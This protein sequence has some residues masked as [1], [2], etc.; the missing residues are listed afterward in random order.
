MLLERKVGKEVNDKSVVKTKV[1]VGVRG[2]KD[3]QSSKRTG[4]HRDGVQHWYKCIDT[5]NL[6]LTWH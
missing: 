1:T 2:N 6:V 5:T 4:R 3:Q